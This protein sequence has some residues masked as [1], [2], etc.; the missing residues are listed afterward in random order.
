MTCD[1]SKCYTILRKNGFSL[2][3]SDDIYLN[4][5][6]ELSKNIRG[7]IL[8]NFYSTTVEQAMEHLVSSELGLRQ[9]EAK[10]RLSTYGH[11][12]LD[13]K[14]GVPPWMIFVN[15]FKS[16]IIFILIGATVISALLHEWIEPM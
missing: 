13:R 10:K 2:M 11:N 14:Q 1:P 5:L 3:L 4:T 15:Q 8:E 9:Q 6:C 7:G 12:E 16:F